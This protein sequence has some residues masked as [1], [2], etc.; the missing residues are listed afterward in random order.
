MLFDDDEQLE[1]RHVI[2]LA[3]HDVSI[4]SGGD[5]TP[6]G[7]LFIKRNAICLSR[8][9]DGP[10]VGP[11]SQLSKPFY[12]FSENCSAKEDFYFALLR[13]QEQTLGS[14]RKA[15]NPL[16]FKIQNI[17]NLVQK[18][19]SSEDQRETRWLNALLG[20]IFLGVYQT[21]DLENFIRKMIT[22]KISRVKRP[23]FLSGISLRRVDT[24]DAA[25]YFSNPRLKDLTVEG[26]CVIEADVRYTGNF[27]IEVAAT[28][29][30]DLGTRFKVR[31][32][33][34]VLAVVVRKVE[35]HVF[36][37]IKPPPSNRLWFSFQAM[38]KLEMTIEPIVSSRQ[39]TYTLI[40]RQIENRIKEVVAESVVSPFWDD[41]P[42]FRTEHKRWRGGIWEEDDSVV[43]PSDLETSAAQEGDVD[44]VDRLE[45]SG[46]PAADM[47]PMEKSYSLPVIEHTPPTG[48]FGRKLTPKT[49]TSPKPSASST[50][51]DLRSAPQAIPRSMRS[52]S[53]AD[54]VVGTDASHADIF[55]ASSSPPDHASSMM[56]AL[57]ARSHS[58]SPSH[59]PV[60][61]SPARP[62]PVFKP[63]GA[64]GNSSS[65]SSREATDTERDAERTPKTDARRGTASSSESLGILDEAVAAASNARASLSNVKGSLRSQT[66]SISRGFFRRQDSGT[67]SNSGVSGA[68]TLNSEGTSSTSTTGTG[69]T[70][71]RNTLAVVGN[72]AAQARNWGWNALQ[73]HKDKQD[74]AGANSSSDSVNKVDLSQP[75]G[76]GRPLPPPGTPLPPPERNS[77]KSIP[78]PKRKTIPPP[79]LP[80]QSRIASDG[81]GPGE[82]LGSPSS[83][84]SDQ[85]RGGQDRSVVEQAQIETLK[86]DT[87]R[88][89]PPPPLPKRR[90]LS[91]DNDGD[92][93]IGG[94]EDLLVVAAPD[95][96]QPGTP[97]PSTPLTEEPPALTSVPPSLPYVQPW[98]EEADD[99]DPKTS[100]SSLAR[101]AAGA[102]VASAS[103]TESLRGEQSLQREPPSPTR[104]KSVSEGDL[105]TSMHPG[106]ETDRLD[107][108]SERDLEHH[109]L[110]HGPITA[111]PVVMDDEEEDDDDGYS[112]WMDNTG[113]EDESHQ[114]A[115]TPEPAK[116]DVAIPERSS[117]NP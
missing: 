81:V 53:S 51:L 104:S 108:D 21:K 113:V 107:R 101:A 116:A 19:H 65:S 47:R 94:G 27:R 88:P 22:K 15:P 57:R 49:P 98:V 78:V 14:D 92:V 85:H 63:A 28:A 99:E 115:P 55:K 76:R 9:K 8:R 87:R 17:I 102:G 36:F 4:Y 72:A 34:L 110:E 74:G 58:N 23:S 46:D 62:P 24:G 96:S 10:E 29:R 60:S 95:D 106:L 42:F 40:L 69:G 30:I 91:M 97:Q 68:G 43:P 25:P 75:M 93:G 105:A 52:G 11:D 20:R 86:A 117:S 77:K 54:P 2:S 31:E 32:V 73:R 5:V 13:N 67:S 12:L 114:Y 26:E 89:V 66:G 33:D 79:L 109:R 59:T 64:G 1:V 41:V 83:S 45:E 90:Q 111:I 7:E 48:L 44:T 70:Q 80:D 39:I 56:A 71:K 50:S 61:G 112:G 84:R 38:P 3:H 6:E 18:L 35:G 100:S 16:Q 37:K 103:R 82:A